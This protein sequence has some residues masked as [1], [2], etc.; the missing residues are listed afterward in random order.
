VSFVY[1]EP[2]IELTC[3]TVEQAISIARERKARRD[4]RPLAL[5]SVVRSEPV[6]GG[7]AR[8]T[9]I[10]KWAQLVDGFSYYVFDPRA[11]QHIQAGGRDE[12]ER[13]ILELMPHAIARI[14]KRATVHEVDENG[15]IVRKIN[16]KGVV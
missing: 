5:V 14:D 15:N 11:G 6:M 2:E 13:V 7:H 12:A 3:S 8:T 1:R 9:P 4:L 10:T 16:W